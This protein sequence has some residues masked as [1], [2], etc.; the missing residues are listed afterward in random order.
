MKKGNNTIK[1]QINPK[2]NKEKLSSR[3]SIYQINKE[4]IYDIYDFCVK[5]SNGFSGKVEKACFK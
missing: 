2:D 5:I 4:N 3:S 1:S